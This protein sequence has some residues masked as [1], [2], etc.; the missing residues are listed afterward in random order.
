MNP[1]NPWSRRSFLRAAGVSL[2]LPLLPS[3][4]PRDAWAQDGTP[5]VRLLYYYV[6]CGIHMAH[7]TPNATG[8]GYDLPPI[9][10][11]LAS[12]QDK[13][14]V[15]SGLANMSGRDSRPG[16]HARG[17]GCFITCELPTYG[18]VLLGPSIDQ[19]V[20]A[21]IGD[22]TPFPSLQ[23]GIDGGANSGNCDSGYAC[24]YQRSISWVNDT[25]PL[26]K[27]VDP[28]I[29]FDQ[30]F[31]G[32]GGEDPVLAERRRQLKLS[33]LDNV[34][35]DATRLQSRM[36]ASDKVKLDQYLT[37]VREVEKRIDALGTNV[38][39]PPDRPGRGLDVPT[40]VDIMSDL[41]KI[42][43]ECDL[44]RVITFMLANGGSGRSH[45]W[46][47]T[48][49]NHHGFSHHQG[50]PA[51][52]LAL[53]QINT[54]EIEVFASF[55]AKLDGVSETNGTLLD[56]SLIMLG[57][58]ISDGN[59][60]NHDDLPVLLAGGGGGAVTPGRHI[61][62]NVSDREPVANLLLSMADAAGVPLTRFGSDGT[63]QLPGLA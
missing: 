32:V 36:A 5:P 49:G 3:L 52:H 54:W 19:V 43:F 30:L 33:I 39:V 14:S 46:I 15:I 44:T 62:F 37:G 57:S 25:T 38:C 26:P 40:R 51:S 45:S 10:K 20:A 21:S 34:A 12:I 8:P 16:D 27:I 24:A 61:A 23:L 41:M 53:S 13:V 17:T 50:N 47:G 22:Q 60:H 59:R 9:L 58:E 7:W 29:L 55:L 11:P 4:L 18:S 2:S 56:N 1:S 63:R 35:Q 28:R 31:T 48:P 42:A 6:P